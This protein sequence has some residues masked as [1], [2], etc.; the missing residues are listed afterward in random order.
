MQQE[1]I[2]T[3][4][5]DKAFASGSGDVSGA[6]VNLKANTCLSFDT[7]LSLFADMHVPH[8]YHM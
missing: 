6:V 5:G 7:I 3:N 8:P 1:N 2:L 4:T